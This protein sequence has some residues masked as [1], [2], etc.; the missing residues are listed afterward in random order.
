MIAGVRG[1]V[2]AIEPSA[3]VIDLHGFLVRVH[4]SGRSAGAAGAMGDRV[5]LVT[6]LV[7]REDAL[8]LYGFIDQDELEL[9]QMLL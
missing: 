3:L 9:F 4:T 2:A 5:S 6:H 8:T 7:V 1:V